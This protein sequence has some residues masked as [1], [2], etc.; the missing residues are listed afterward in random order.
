MA[1]GDVACGANNDLRHQQGTTKRGE[2]N[3]HDGEKLGLWRPWRLT[4]EP[5]LFLMEVPLEVGMKA[6]AF[7]L[8]PNPLLAPVPALD[9][10]VPFPTATA[11]PE[12]VVIV[13]SV[14][15]AVEG[16]SRPSSTWRV[17]IYGASSFHESS[18]TRTSVG[19]TVP[20]SR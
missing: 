7:E 15:R 19:S 3:P 11:V 13:E 5:S 6:V 14:E 1:K 12:S 20:S 18:S 17:W 9:D 10:V 8:S 2:Q 16:R 4:L